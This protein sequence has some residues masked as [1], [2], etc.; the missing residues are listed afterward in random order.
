MMEKKNRSTGATKCQPA[1]AFTLL[2]CTVPTGC[3][4]VPERQYVLYLMLPVGPVQTYRGQYVP[5]VTNRMNLL[6]RCITFSSGESD[7]HVPC[8]Y[9]PCPVSSECTVK[10]LLGTEWRFQ[11]AR[12][13]D[14][15]VQRAQPSL[16]RQRWNRKLGG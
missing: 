6:S 9:H 14:A 5:T 8:M 11:A 12:G 13:L 3:T 2:Y 4:L 7:M 1:G 15:D 16:K 10:C